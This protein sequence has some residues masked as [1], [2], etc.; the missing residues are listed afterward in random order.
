MKVCLSGIVLSPLYVPAYCEVVG[1]GVQMLRSVEARKR[2][3]QRGLGAE[4]LTME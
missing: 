4:R 3:F 1:G 2:G